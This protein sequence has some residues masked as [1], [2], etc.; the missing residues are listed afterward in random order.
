MSLPGKDWKTISAAYQ[1]L[2]KQGKLNMRINNQASFDAGRA[3]GIDTGFYRSRKAITLTP[4][5]KFSRTDRGGPNG[6]L[7]EDYEGYPG[8]RG[9]M[10]HDQDELN[11]MVWR[12]TPGLAVTHCIGDKAA[13]M[14]IDAVEYALKKIRDPTTGTAS[15]TF[16]LLT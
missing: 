3:E 8:E 10:M 4:A 16:R 13:D 12:T 6:L 2:E 15:S 1:N 5:L 11:D 9:I 14:M 7:R